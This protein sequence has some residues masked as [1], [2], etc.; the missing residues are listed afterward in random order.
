MITRRITFFC[1]G[2]FIL[3]LGISLMIIADIG[4]GAWDALNVGLSKTIGLT[5]GNWVMIVGILIMLVNA[6]LLQA[7]PEFLAIGTIILIGFFIDF[8]L[9]IAFDEWN[10]EGWIVQFL[11]LLAGLV[12]A[13]LGIAIYLQAKFPLSPLDNLMLAISKRFKL[14]VGVSKTIGE[15]TGLILALLS[16]GPIGIG[17]LVCTFGIGPI[18]QFFFPYCERLMEKGLRSR[19]DLDELR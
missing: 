7:R 12:I 14:K 1:V 19:V 6:L 11:V 17:T 18:I 13:S 5:V 10:P 3:A 16:G 4:A 8:W 9:L 15:A 2:L